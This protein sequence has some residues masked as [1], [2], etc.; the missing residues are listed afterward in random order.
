MKTGNHAVLFGE[1]PLHAIPHHALILDAML[2]AQQPAIDDVPFV[3]S[4]GL[5]IQKVRFPVLKFKIEFKRIPAGGVV[6]I[7]RLRLQPAFPFPDDQDLRF[8]LFHST[9]PIC[10]P[11]RALVVALVFLEGRQGRGHPSPL[12]SAP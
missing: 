10:E 2:L 1:Q 9:R 8:F 7:D 12:V 5:E 6:G 4:S 3:A 11:L